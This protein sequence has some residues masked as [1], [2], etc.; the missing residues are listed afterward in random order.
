MSIPL[1]G[2]TVNIELARVD[3]DGV[4]FRVDGCRSP[5]PFD[6]MMQFAG[7]AAFKLDRERRDQTFRLSASCCSTRYSECDESTL[8]RFSLTLTGFDKDYYRAHV[9][10][11]RAR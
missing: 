9:V 5:P 3:S 11:N 1:A 6:G 4:V 7:V 2:A 8:Q 10:A